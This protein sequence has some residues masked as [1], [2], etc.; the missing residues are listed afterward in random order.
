MIYLPENHCGIS[1]TKIPDGEWAAIDL[2][3]FFDTYIALF[4]KNELTDR[5]N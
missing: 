5:I 4:L 1:S 2:H 3:I